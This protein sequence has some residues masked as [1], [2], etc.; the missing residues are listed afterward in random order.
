MTLGVVGWHHSSFNKNPPEAK[1]MEAIIQSKT[2]TT[3]PLTYGL[4]KRSISPI[5]LGREKNKGIFTLQKQEEEITVSNVLKGKNRMS[6]SP[7]EI[8]SI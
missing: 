7:L 3:S 6:K 8:S 5:H 1:H 4:G 2:T